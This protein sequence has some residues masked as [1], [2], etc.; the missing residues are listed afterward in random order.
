VACVVS[1]AKNLA[2]VV[3][4]SDSPGNDSSMYL[5]ASKLKISINFYYEFKK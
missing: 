2:A 5:S 1:V 3:N 4:D